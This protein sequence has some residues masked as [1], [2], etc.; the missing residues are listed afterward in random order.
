MMGRDRPDNP[1]E[2]LRDQVLSVRPDALA[3]APTRE[4]PHVWAALMEWGIDDELAMLVTIADGTVSLYLSSGGG[5]IGAGADDNVRRA[6]TEFLDVAEAHRDFLLPAKRVSRLKSGRARFHVRTFTAEL[7]GEADE[8]ELGE[9]RHALSPLFIAAQDVLTAIR[10]AS[11]GESE[12]LSDGPPPGT[13][14]SLEIAEPPD[15]VERVTARDPDAATI[16]RTVHKLA[17]DPITFVVLKVDEDNWMEGSGSRDPTDGFS[18]RVMLDGEERV[19][20]RAPESLD[21]IIA[22]LQSYRAGDGRWREMIEWD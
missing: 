5:V 17:W 20:S 15:N 12:P 2:R 4:R 19:S 22:L 21:E 6:A 9:E 3:L 11:P 10:E 13:S 7:T 1:F 18:A 14:M 16:A 8:N